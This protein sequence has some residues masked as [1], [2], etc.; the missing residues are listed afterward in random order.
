MS[1][2]AEIAEN[3]RGNS[4]YPQNLHFNERRETVNTEV[5]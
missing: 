1:G 3:K 2:S 4:L 5:K